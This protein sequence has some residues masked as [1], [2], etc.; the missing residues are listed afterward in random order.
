MLYAFFGGRGE[1][2]RD[3]FARQINAAIASGASGV[4][5]LGLGTEVAKLGREERRAAV[6][7]VINIVAG[8]LPVAVTIAEGNVADM[9]ESAAFARNAGA[10]WLIL[11]PPRPPAS[12]AD[13]IRL[14]G[15]VAD[16]VGCPIGIQN[17]P[18]FLGIG[19]SPAELLALHVAHPNVQV[20]KAESSAVVVANVVAAI[21]GRLKV[22]NGRAGLELTDNFRA[23][24]DGMI[25]GIET[26]DV[27]VGIEKAM[28]A[29]EEAQAEDLY[30]KV[31]PAL[32]FIMQGLAHFVLY[33]KLIAAHRLNLAPSANRIP[34]DIAT[35][36]GA[37][38]A[39]RFAT[40]LGPLPG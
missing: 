10:S 32:S 11:Q 39:R 38:W 20:V 1:L 24:V 6:E 29:G 13:L 3:A 5:V 2:L 19:L 36:P 14:F 40:E 4:A 9:I 7:W 27:Q 25:P 18:E 34:S 26:I 28:R 30:R 31:L 23:G 21:G 37:A 35:Q 16:R 33:G 22:F 8:R 15:Q 12:G 17:A